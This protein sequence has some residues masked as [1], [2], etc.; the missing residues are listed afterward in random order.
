MGKTSTSIGHTPGLLGGKDM[1]LTFL[2]GSGKVW[3]LL[4]TYAA[5]GIET[6]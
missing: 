3:Q 1:A 6:D 5:I 2:R 4:R